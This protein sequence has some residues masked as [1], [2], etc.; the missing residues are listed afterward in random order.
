MGRMYDLDS[1][2]VVLCFE[3]V[4]KST[5]ALASATLVAIKYVCLINYI[6]HVCQCILKHE[7]YAIIC[8]H[9]L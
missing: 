7:L 9:S 6:M 2:E 5:S 3:H 4:G 8:A 1:Q